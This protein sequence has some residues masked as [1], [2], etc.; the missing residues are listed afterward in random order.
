MSVGGVPTHP[1]PLPIL[2][3]ARLHSQP[4]PWFQRSLLVWLCPPYNPQP[5]AWPQEKSLPLGTKP[6][7][8]LSPSCHLVSGGSTGALVKPQFRWLL[9]GSVTWLK[10]H[11][12]MFRGPALAGNVL[13]AGSAKGRLSQC[14]HGLL[15]DT[16]TWYAG[17]EVL[18]WEQSCGAGFV[19]PAA[20]SP[21]VQPAQGLS[22]WLVGA[23]WPS[24]GA[25]GCF[26]VSSGLLE[27][28][29]SWQSSWY[30]GLFLDGGVSVCGCGKTQEESL[31]L[32]AS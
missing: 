29:N 7:T 27:P 17:R 3:N 28:E 12:Y 32:A 22:L 11:Q 30:L 31:R 15:R 8:S 9:P 23:F 24:K 16:C 5:S 25:V 13:E 19:R 14:C 20:R 21:A 18:G 10:L 26:L 4:I 6:W 1:L 2:E